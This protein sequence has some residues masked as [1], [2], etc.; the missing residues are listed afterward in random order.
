MDSKAL[1]LTN[2]PYWPLL[3]KNNLPSLVD[4]EHWLAHSATFLPQTTKGLLK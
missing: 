1:Q 4:E 3:T 2:S